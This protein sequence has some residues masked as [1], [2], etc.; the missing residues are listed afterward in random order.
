MEWSNRIGFI[1]GRL[2]PLVDQKIQAFPWEH[3]KSEFPAAKDLGLR[4][5]E[6]TLDAERIYENPF[7]KA[8]G[9]VQQLCR[10]NQLRIPSLTGDFFMQEPFFHRD[11]EVRLDTLKAVIRSCGDHGTE[12]LI[13]PL[14]DNASLTGPELEKDLIHG[15]IE[16]EKELQ[17]SGV[18]VAF[19]SDY[20]PQELAR[21]IEMLPSS[22]FGINYDS[23][24]SASLGYDVQ[25]E[26]SS[27]GPRVLNVHIKDRIR[28]GTTVPLGEGDVQWSPLFGCLKN[29]EGNIILQTARAKKG[30]HSE[31]LRKYREFVLEGLS[32]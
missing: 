1:Q 20:G 6:W 31:V 24:N 14:V 13:I 11:R 30:N 5:M 26:F 29:Y 21:F 8:S 28:G 23:G 16:V 15:M 18:K 2:S 10:E 25:E 17:S 32:S 27:Y 7:L 22:S 12:F 9:E 3:W 19:E 4:L